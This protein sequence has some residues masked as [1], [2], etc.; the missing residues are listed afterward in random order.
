VAERA[1]VDGCCSGEDVAKMA[2]LEA[3][4]AVVATTVVA[5]LGAKAEVAKAVMMAMAN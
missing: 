3:A 1:H 5:T 2:A 4:R